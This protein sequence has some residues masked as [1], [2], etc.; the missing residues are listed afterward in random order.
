MYRI[1]PV[2]LAMVG[3]GAGEAMARKT[4]PR[5]A[6]V[7]PPRGINVTYALK[8]FVDRI[9]QAIGN[10]VT[11]QGYRG[12]SFGRN[13]RKYVDM[14]KGGVADIAI[15]MKK[16]KWNSLARD[17]GNGFD[18]TAAKFRNKIA[19]TRKVIEASD[20]DVAQGFKFVQPVHQA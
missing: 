6:S 17:G 15:F 10:E 2:F 13:P 14:V 11:A 9:N 4:M 8:P 16:N 7:T 5:V 12:G 18:K 19:G 20:A 1:L 3:F